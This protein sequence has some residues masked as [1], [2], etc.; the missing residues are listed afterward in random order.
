[1]DLII[2]TDSGNL[3]SDTQMLM[4]GNGY[5]ITQCSLRASLPGVMMCKEVMKYENGVSVHTDYLQ[6]ALIGSMQEK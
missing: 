2:V 5:C 4:C 1:M 6:A 3:L